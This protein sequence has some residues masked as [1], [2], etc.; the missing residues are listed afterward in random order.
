LDLTASTAELGKDAKSDLKKKKAT[1]PS[2][3]GIEES[4]KRAQ[5]LLNCSLDAIAP[6]GK[7]GEPLAAIARFIVERRS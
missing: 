2:L 6:F 5:T 3:L 4:K 1:Y 7:N